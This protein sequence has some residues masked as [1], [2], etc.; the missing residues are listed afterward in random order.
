VPVSGRIERSGIDGFDALHGA[1]VE[2]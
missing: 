1:S 2:D